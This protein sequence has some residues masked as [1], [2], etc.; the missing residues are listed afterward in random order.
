MECLHSLYKDLLMKYTLLL[1]ST[2]NQM[3]VC[4]YG[5]I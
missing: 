2:I 3:Y 1:Y 5:D 4:I